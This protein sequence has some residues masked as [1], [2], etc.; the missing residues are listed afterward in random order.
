MTF[1]RIA[2]FSLLAGSL[3]VV[4]PLP[5]FAA[6]GSATVKAVDTDH[7]GT[8]DMNE[9][10]TAAMAKFTMADKDKDGTVDSKEAG[11]DVTKADTDK[12]GTLDKAETETALGSTFKAADTDND[13]TVDAKEL[14]TP[15]GQKLSSMMH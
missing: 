2:A 9:A 8:I 15:A 5:S 14:A 3:A 10:K 6:D 13:G 11:M 7:D 12:D 1:A 4:A